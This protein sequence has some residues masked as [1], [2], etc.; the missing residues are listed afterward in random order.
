MRK[1]SNALWRDYDVHLAIEEPLF[2]M[3]KTFIPEEKLTEI[4][5]IMAARRCK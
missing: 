2:D 3:G 4:G 5:E 1:R